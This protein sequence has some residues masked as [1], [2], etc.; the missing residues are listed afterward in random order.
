MIESV[1]FK[2]F[3][4]LRDTTLPLGRFT[5][6][7]GPNGSGKSTALDALEL[8]VQPTRVPTDR[9]VSVG[10]ALTEEARITIH[11]ADSQSRQESVYVYWRGGRVGVGGSRQ[12]A[13]APEASDCW[14][15]LQSLQVY[16]LDA[17]AIAAPVQLR[18]R[19]ALAANGG[20]LAGVLDQLR[21]QS[22]ERFEALN[23]ELSRWMP[24]FDRVLFETPAQ[25]S[26][27]IRLR[28][29]VGGH[30]IPAADLSQGTLIALA[31]LT[32]AYLPEPP[33]VIGLE[34]PDRGLHPRLLRDV[35]D[36]IYRLAYPEQFGEQREP[37]Q[38][39][40]T[41]HSPYFL[42]LFRDHPEEIVIAEKAGNEARFHKLTDRSDL[43]E[44]LADAHLGEVWY[45]GV[46]GGVPANR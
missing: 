24:E 4:V 35:R 14:R 8:A 17:K 34:E 22:P 5:L 13:P 41:T 31:I 11:W 7:V 6:L 18:P 12:T 3:K 1:Q 32:L 43:K 44:I 26:R 28:L 38:V 37:V 20:Q 16:S 15:A 30:A 33:A 40:A 29:A 39:I 36:A 45:S 46:L 10:T 21:D 42:D 25:G 23:L 2:N 9:I 27:S 19:M